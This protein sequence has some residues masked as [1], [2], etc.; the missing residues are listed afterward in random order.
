LKP[1]HLNL[2]SRPF[3][4]YRPY[5][6]VVVVSSLLIAFLTL[7]NFDTWYRYRNE[8]K[9]TRGKIAMLERQIEDEQRQTD[10]VNQ[11]LRSVD[12]KLLA[13]QAQY[14]N[15][16]LAERAFSW[17]ELLDRLEHVLPDDVRIESVSPSFSKDGTVHLSMSCVAKTGQGMPT[18]LDRFN[19]NL[20]FS[21]AF[22]NNED[23]TDQ[24]YRFT[25]GVDYHP[26]IARQVE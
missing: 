17:S 23:H 15:A 5:V 24:G 14:A 18:T 10:A 6:G 4:D 9:A 16:R 1:I 19:R 26:S 12:L 8:T 7:T 13:L 2:A 20:N 3:R 11:R 22:P 21:S 25:L